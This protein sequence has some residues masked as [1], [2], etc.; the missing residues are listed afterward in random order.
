M[1]NPPLK[2]I[3]I[4]AVIILGVVLRILA[5]FRGHNDDINTFLTV[6]K[7]MSEGKNVYTYFNPSPYGPVY[8]L[9]LGLFYKIISLIS[10]PAIV[11]I[12]LRF[13]ETLFL[14]A[15]DV[16]ITAIMLRSF[17]MIA[18]VLFFLNP[19]SIIITGYHSQID[20]FAIFMGMLAVSIFAQNKRL[21]FTRKQIAGLIILGLSLMVKHIFLAFPF[22]LAVKQKNWKAR[23]ITL[24]VPLIIFIAGFLPF[25]DTGLKS[26]IDNIFGYHSGNN[27][28][29]FYFL[30]P[31]AI[32]LYISSYVIFYIALIIFGIIF[33]RV[34]ALRSLLY[35]LGILLIFSPSI[36]PQY[37][38]IPVALMAAS[39]NIFYLLYTLLGT[40]DFI[41]VNVDEL[42]FREFARF[43]PSPIFKA[44][45]GYRGADDWLVVFLAV[46][47][48]WMF[49]GKKVVRELLHYL[50]IIINPRRV[51]I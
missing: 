45:S 21:D 22:W 6:A 7:L 16:G 50:Q 18:A 3:I 12:V 46:G 23:I 10:S 38:V 43:I 15:I 32:N 19:I 51:N 8:Y 14:T 30:L 28:P 4:T 48:L 25:I 11:P 9:L 44:I 49:K 24:I 41:F 20:N 33:Y 13:T 34:S 39:P 26:I 42:H 40:I 27:A 1:R 37:I 2:K 29:F 36:S 47:F 17:G 35:Y 5:A 31:K